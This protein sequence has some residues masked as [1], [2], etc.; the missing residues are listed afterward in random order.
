MTDHKW[1]EYYERLQRE[2]WLDIS[3]AR[4]P[5]RHDPADSYASYVAYCER[6]GIQSTN[7][8]A[9]AHETHVT[10]AE[11][12]PMTRPSTIWRQEGEEDGKA[13]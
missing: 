13:N 6:L 3:G 5:T 1:R 2:N 9:Y 4:I 7:K 11:N 12:R 10:A 8:L